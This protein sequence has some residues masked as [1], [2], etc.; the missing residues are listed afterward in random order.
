MGT[1]GARVKHECPRGL[2]EI[3]TFAPSKLLG[4]EPAGA[5]E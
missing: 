3:C 1:D 5:P 4:R 2:R